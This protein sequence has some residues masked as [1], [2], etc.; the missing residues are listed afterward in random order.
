VLLHARA[1][2]G[3]ANVPAEHD[4]SACPQCLALYEAKKADFLDEPA[5]FYAE[6]PATDSQAF[7]ESGSPRFTLTPGEERTLEPRFRGRLEHRM[8][9]REAS[10]EFVADDDGDLYLNTLTNDPARTY[11]LAVDPAM[12]VGG[13]ATCATVLSV[14][15]DGHS[16]EVAGIFHS[17][18]TEPQAAAKQI[19]LLGRYFRGRGPA[20]L[21]G[22]EGNQNSSTTILLHLIQSNYPNLYIDRDYIKRNAQYAANIG[23]IHTRRGARDAWI[24]LVATWLAEDRYEGLPPVTWGE[25]RTFV[26]KPTGKIEHDVGC[27]DDTVLSLAMASKILE[28]TEEAWRRPAGAM[29]RTRSWTSTLG[30]DP[31]A[32]DNDLREKRELSEADAA[33]LSPSWYEQPEDP[34]W[35]LR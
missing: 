7:A 1:H 31:F 6:Y 10:V 23:V 12:G 5:L 28:E 9:G 4:A 2:L 13:D 14:A 29:S 19:A 15:E 3:L 8:A 17:R 30:F 33:W 22:V 27:H 32:E 11:V 34:S 25:I 16:V 20:A 26:R 21:L 18:F 24:N 35:I